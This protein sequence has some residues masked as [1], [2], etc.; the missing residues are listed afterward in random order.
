MIDRIGS[1]PVVEAGNLRYCRDAGAAKQVHQVKI[2]HQF[3]ALRQAARA[4][5][6]STNRILAPAKAVGRPRGG[7]Q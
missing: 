2:N 3:H 7:E 5:A 1:I 6:K 4:A